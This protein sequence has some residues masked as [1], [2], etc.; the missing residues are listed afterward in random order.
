[1]K[2]CNFTHSP[3]PCSIV[4]IFSCTH[5]ER[6]RAWVSSFI[7]V[8]GPSIVYRYLRVGYNVW[9]L[10]LTQLFAV[11]RCVWRKKSKEKKAKL[12]VKLVWLLSLFSLSMT[13]SSSSVYTSHH[14]PK[15]DWW[16]S[17]SW[18]CF[19]SPSWAVSNYARWSLGKNVIFEFPFHCRSFFIRSRKKSLMNHIWWTARLGSVQ[20]KVFSLKARSRGSTRRRWKIEHSKATNE[21]TYDA[22]HN[23]DRFSFLVVFLSFPKIMYIKWQQSTMS[24]KKEPARER[25]WNLIFFSWFSFPHCA[26]RRQRKTPSDDKS[27]Y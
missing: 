6:E 5:S 4:F 7:Y 19:F 16:W 9:R 11:C 23:C 27:Y 17:F 14:H 1:M 20:S 12:R 21:A 8:W 22:W 10:Q 18:R 25:L 24:Q 15:L 13:S 26:R 3:K 2:W